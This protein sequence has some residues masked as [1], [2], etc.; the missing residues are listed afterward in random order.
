[1]PAETIRTVFGALAY[2]ATAAY[3]I[4]AYAAILGGGRT[5]SAPS[6]TTPEPLSVLVPL[7]GVFEGL[8]ACLESLFG[9]DHPCFEILF[10]THDPNDPALALVEAVRRRHPTCRSRT[11]V[12]PVPSAGV[13]PKV[14]TLEALEPRAEHELLVLI[15]ADI[16]LAPD[17]LRRV[18]APLSDPQTGLVTCPYGAALPA[19]VGFWSRLAALYVGDWFYTSV[20]AATLVAPDAHGF[21]ATLALRRST[22][23]A[24]GGFGPLRT[25][26][27]DD[28][29]LARRVRALGLRTGVLEA[30]ARTVIT[31]T[32]FGD[33]W[34][35]EK[36]WL[37][38]VRALD[39]WGYLGLPVSLTFVV[40]LLG[41]ALLGATSLAWAGF[42]I[43]ALGRLVLHFLVKNRSRSDGK[44]A[45]ALLL[46][47]RD[48]VTLAEWTV[49]LV[50]RRLRWKASLL[51]IDDRGQLEDNDP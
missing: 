23:R 22:L 9:Q 4:L 12:S 45:D 16:V 42:L 5:L 2:S 10:G 3:L 37:G 39:P 30:G 44:A 21:G 20:L 17:H 24:S 1:M 46:P 38:T 19:P 33:L 41:L 25:V 7:H 14:V 26:L 35:H 8:E 40:L 6:S 49:A 11:V 27:A 36:R 34:A 48:F 28:H 29:V 50:A 15:D 51:V 43:L 47:L 31:E 18:T 32:T 13:N